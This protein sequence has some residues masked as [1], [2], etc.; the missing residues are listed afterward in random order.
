MVVMVRDSVGVVMG[1]VWAGSVVVMGIHSQASAIAS[2]GTATERWCAVKKKS[3]QLGHTKGM[4]LRGSAAA[5]H[6]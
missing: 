6:L 4:H 2:F 1:C 5:V 3:S